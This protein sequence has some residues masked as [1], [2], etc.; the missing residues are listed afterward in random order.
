M[1]QYTTKLRM[2]NPWSAKFLKIHLEVEWVDLWQL[3]SLKP[4][5]YAERPDYL[6][7]CIA[8]VWEGLSWRRGLLKTLMVGHEGSSAGSYLADPTSPIP[9][10]CAVIILFKSV[11]VDQLSWQALKELIH[12]LYCKNSHFVCNRVT[13]TTPNPTAQWRQY[14]TFNGETHVTRW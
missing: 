11:P 13:E 8:I 1:W 4:L 10:H 9:S 5:S 3:L 12:R 2:F 7:D 6:P 14:V